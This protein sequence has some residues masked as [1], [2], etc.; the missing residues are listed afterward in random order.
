MRSSRTHAG[1]VGVQHERAGYAEEIVVTLSRQ[2]TERY[3]RGV[4][5]TNLTRMVRFARVFPERAIVATL[6]QQLSWSHF[7]ALVA[8]QKCMGVGHDDFYLGVLRYSRPPRRLVAVELKVGTF[9]PAHEGS[10]PTGAMTTL[11]TS[12]TRGQPRSANVCTM[13]S[14][15][16]PLVSR[17]L[18]LAGDSACD[19]VDEPRW[20]SEAVDDLQS[21]CDSFVHRQDQSVAWAPLDERR[22]RGVTCMPA[23]P[24]RNLRGSVVGV[25]VTAFVPHLPALLGRRS[26]RVLGGLAG[27]E[28]PAAPGGR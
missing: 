28:A 13:L 14:T 9:T 8:R 18:R 25:D 1:R 10:G 15:V 23:R 5:R 19:V 27:P 3:G 21:G 4:D 7:Q 17:T 26:L 12:A 6:G 24:R 16:L 20:V 11:L 2:L 22:K